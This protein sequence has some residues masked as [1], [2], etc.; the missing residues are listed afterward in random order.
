MVNLFKSLLLSA[1]IGTLTINKSWAEWREDAGWETL[2][3]YAGASIPNGSSLYLEITEAYAN[4]T[5]FPYM[6]NTGLTGLNGITFTN[7]T[8]T[9][10][11]VSGH[12]NSVSRN[13]FSATESLLTGVT[14]VG[15]RSA[16]DF[17][18]NFLD[19]SGSVSASTAQV[20]S[21]AYIGSASPANEA[22]YNEFIKRFDFFTQN[23]G[24]LNIVG[25]N[26]GDSNI[27]PPLFNSAYNSISVGRTDGLHSHGFTPANYPGPGRQKPEIVSNSIGNRTSFA[28]GA[29]SSAASLLNAKAMQSMNIDAT[30]SDTIKACLFAGATKTRLLSWSQTTSEPLDTRYGVG[31]MNIFN[32]YRI[33]ERAESAAPNVHHRGWSR[34]QIT[35]STPITYT[36]TTPNLKPP[37]TLSAALVWQRNVTQSGDMMFPTYTYENLSNLQLELLNQG[38][39]T[40]QT[41]NSTVGNIEHIWN[42]QLEPNTIYSLRVSSS[43]GT[44]LFSLAWHVGGKPTAEMTIAPDTSHVDVNFTDLKVGNSYVIQR[45]ADMQTWSTIHNFVAT[46]TS[47]SWQDTTNPV[48]GSAFYRIFSFDP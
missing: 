38:G 19:T 45:S 35:T 33:I 47:T 42:Q 5:T 34:D 9:S 14:Q 37:L 41:S 27:I 29:V 8:N 4:N 20:M 30:H 17:L 1:C 11:A 26:N 48:N 15:V 3:L 18:N 12:A 16:N 44:D 6:P 13:Y 36:F 43:S 2:L 46:S 32:S 24:T 7:I 39:T 28:T 31:E 25:V 22:N 10:S 23:S 21:H 40:L